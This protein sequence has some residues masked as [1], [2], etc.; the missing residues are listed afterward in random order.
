LGDDKDRPEPVGK[1]YA[2]AC[3]R[4]ARAKFPD[5]LSHNGEIKK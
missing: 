4:P 5:R 2:V 3:R 1:R